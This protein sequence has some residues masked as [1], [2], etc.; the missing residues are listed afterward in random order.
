L[1]QL[2]DDQRALLQRTRRAVLGTT[3]PS[4]RPR[5]VPV[6]FAVLE[7]GPELIVYSA[8][9]DKPKTTRDPHD[10]ARV[11]DILERPEVSLLVDEWDEDWTRLRWLRL[12]GDATL[13]EQAGASA[14]E[15]AAALRELRRRYPQYAT[16]RLEERPIV[17]VR[18]ERV[19]AWSAS[20]S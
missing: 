3:S 1:A 8:L 15:H 5:L 12:D 9:D 4:G 7:S 11:R 16:H 14:T 20:G 19:S 2:T 10:L 18:V 17:R 6:A 13:I